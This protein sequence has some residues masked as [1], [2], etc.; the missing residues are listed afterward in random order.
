MVT[1]KRLVRLILAVASAMQLVVAAGCGPG[2]MSTPT[3][4]PPPTSMP[5]PTSMPPTVT[6]APPALTFELQPNIEEIQVGKEV[7]IVAK[8]EP[9]QKVELTWSVS[10]TSGGKVYPQKGEGVIYTASDKPGTDIVIAEGTTAGGASVKNSRVFKVV[11]QAPTRTPTPTAAPIAKP[12]LTSIPASPSA[13]LSIYAG[14][15]LSAG[16]DMGQNTSAGPQPWV[17][18]MQGYMKMSY[19]SGLDWGTLFIT[20][21]KPR[22][23]PRPGKDF[24]AYKTFSVDLKGEK[25]GELVNI[26]IKDNTD[27]DDGSED[28][29]TVQVTSEWKTYTY[30]LSQF[31]NADLTRLYVVA[32]FVFEPGWP[33][34]TVYFRNIRYLP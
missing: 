24:S 5:A 9:N 8:I 16:Y 20:V 2:P 7:A 30:P 22:N 10:G 32:E 34:E 23:P 18:D 15:R 4:L 29:I 6:Q 25:G 14:E 17:T 11:P 33:P 28:K 13:G 19:P 1:K 27:P 21:G 12:G 31:A 3:P 26:G